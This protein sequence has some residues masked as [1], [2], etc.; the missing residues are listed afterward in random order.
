MRMQLEILVC[1]PDLD[2]IAAWSWSLVILL[3]AGRI[4]S[5]EV[6]RTI[7]DVWYQ[8]DYNNLCHHIYA[9]INAQRLDMPPVPKLGKSRVWSRP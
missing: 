7:L 6:E 9:Y 5:D 2:L 3:A 1:A 4:T 8:S